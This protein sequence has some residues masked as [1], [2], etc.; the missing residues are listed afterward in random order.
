MVSVEM[1][2]I[3]GSGDGVELEDGGGVEG[4]GGGG[5][6]EIMDEGMEG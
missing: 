1:E 5:V 3:S 2:V 6:G 4:G